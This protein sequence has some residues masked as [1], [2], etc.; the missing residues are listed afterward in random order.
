MQVNIGTLA[1]QVLRAS[2]MSLQHSI[3]YSNIRRCIRTPIP[4]PSSKDWT[5]S[6]KLDTSQCPVPAS[7]GE[8]TTL[9][10]IRYV[11]GGRRRAR[12]IMPLALRSDHEAGDLIF[13][14]ETAISE[15]KERELLSPKATV[16]KRTEQSIG[17]KAWKKMTPADQSQAIK[18]M[19]AADCQETTN[20]VDYINFEKSQGL[21]GGDSLVGDLP[22]EE[23]FAVDDEGGKRVRRLKH[24]AQQTSECATAIAKGSAET[25]A[26][27]LSALASSAFRLQPAFV[28]NAEAKCATAHNLTCEWA[29]C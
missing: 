23:A 10:D 7:V 18:V 3:N 15:L 12:N 27:P 25:F 8:H 29:L 19:Y 5:P 16:V 21:I 14:I 22:P 17:A 28:Q 6:Y 13:A 11:G 4:R 20:P 1:L 9:V 24:A 2:D 26:V